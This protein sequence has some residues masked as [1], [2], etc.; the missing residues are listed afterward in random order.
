MQQR[1]VCV[2]LPLP[3]VLGRCRTPSSTLPTPLLSPPPPPWSMPQHPPQPLPR[4]RR[5]PLSFPRPILL[6]V[7]L[8]SRPTLSLHSRKQ[9]PKRAEMAEIIKKNMNEDLLVIRLQRVQ[10]RTASSHQARFSWHNSNSI[11][12]QQRM[13]QLLTHPMPH[14]PPTRLHLRRLHSLCR[15][16]FRRL[17]LLPL[18]MFLLFR[19]CLFLLPLPIAVPWT[20]TCHMHTQSH[21]LQHPHRPLRL[22][23]LLLLLH[24]SLLLCA[25]SAHASPNSRQHAQHD[26]QQLLQHMHSLHILLLSHTT[27]T[28]TVS[29]LMVV[30]AL[31]SALTV[32]HSSM[33]H[34]P[35]PITLHSSTASAT[36]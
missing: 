16:C 31:H 12:Q 27:A 11:R 17:H 19:P 2:P 24:P 23:R 22:T 25:C 32:L 15:L 9:R 35:H 5:S 3:R 21:H 36:C 14:M 29:C 30:A 10:R 1:V 4:C 7:L 18:R 6:S 8:A 28:A 20:H 13:Q 26:P 34:S 33:L